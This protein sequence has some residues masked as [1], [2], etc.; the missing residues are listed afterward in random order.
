METGR[1]HSV[2]FCVYVRPA[3]LPS[4]CKTCIS[5]SKE[6]H[7]A[8]PSQTCFHTSCPDAS[9][10]VLIRMVD[11][12]TRLQRERTTKR[13]RRVHCPAP[14]PAGYTGS[15]SRH[16]EPCPVN[17]GDIGWRHGTLCRSL[18]NVSRQ[19]RQG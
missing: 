1:P 2:Y 19:R 6:Q 12:R 7:E 8:S 14:A 3:I 11:T 15:S 13:G 4:I 10:S 9:G 18:R 5:L 16:E 17:T